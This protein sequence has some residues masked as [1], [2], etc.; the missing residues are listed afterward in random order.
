MNQISEW[1]EKWG[2][3]LHPDKCKVM[4]IG[5]RQKHNVTYNIIA[6]NQLIPITETGE[7]KDLG[8]IVD[9]KISFK[10]HINEKCKKARQ[11]TMLIRRSFEY[12]SP[13][14]FRKL[15]IAIVRPHLEYAQSIWSPYHNGEID[16]IEKVQ[17]RATKQIQELRY[18]TYEETLRVLKLP[19][20]KYRRLRG[21]LIEMYKLTHNI[22]NI[23][24]SSLFQ[25][26]ATNR[27]NN[28]IIYKPICRTDKRK[29]FFTNRTI[30]YWNKLDNK[31]VNYDNINI[32]KVNLDNFDS[33]LY[34]STNWD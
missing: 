19:T 5:N 11:L 32:V 24:S 13:E 33:A 3:G 34:Y 10:K 6:N 22:Y 9:S 29:Y 21:D 31:T 20:L 17:R 14:V 16:K 2:M 1:C 26:N 27:G 7:E 12:L 23:D 25:F 18:K 30:N 15:Y 4:K 28:Y 8:V